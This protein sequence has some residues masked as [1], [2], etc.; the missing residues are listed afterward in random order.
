MNNT[1]KRCPS[2]F[3]LCN[4]MML[5]PLTCFAVGGDLE[6]L[7]QDCALAPTP[8]QTSATRFS[9]TVPYSFSDL[10]PD[11]SAIYIVC[12]LDGGNSDFSRYGPN[13]KLI[14]VQG[15]NANGQLTFYWGVVSRPHGGQCSNSE[16]S[17]VYGDYFGVTQAGC[18]VFPVDGVTFGGSNCSESAANQYDPFE[19]GSTV[20][21]VA[22]F[23][24]SQCQWDVSP[25]LPT[26]AYGVQRHLLTN[27]APVLNVHGNF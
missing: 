5:F 3:L 11:I 9:V 14:P 6:A 17:Q 20:N 4:L 25:T 18:R 19:A 15:G 24:T 23:N 26:A 21:P 1:G 10:H 27:P 2:F 7:G 13:A 22:G 16:I 8:S 12:E